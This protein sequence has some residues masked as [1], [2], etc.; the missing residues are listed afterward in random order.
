VAHPNFLDARHGRADQFGHG[1]FQRIGNA[2]AGSTSGGLLDSRDD[3]G[4]GVAQNRRSPGAYVID[5]LGPID[6]VDVRLFGPFSEEWLASHRAES[7]HRR[8]Y[9]TGNVAQRFGKESF[10]FGPRNHR[11]NL[12]FS[13]PNARRFFA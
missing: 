4:M 8:V 11:R 9:T 7:S 12:A 5:I 13:V 1:H 10:G 2:K 6:I 3:P